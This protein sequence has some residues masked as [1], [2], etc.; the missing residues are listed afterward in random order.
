MRVF[1]DGEWVIF[2]RQHQASPLPGSCGRGTKT[3]NNSSNNHNSK[4]D[5]K[6]NG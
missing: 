6:Q 2:S 5:N 3:N 1:G 4:R